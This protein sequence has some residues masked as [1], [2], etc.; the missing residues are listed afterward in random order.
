MCPLFL[1]TFVSRT[2][3]EDELIFKSNVIKHGDSAFIF[4]TKSNVLH[5]NV[6]LTLTPIMHPPVHCD[7]LFTSCG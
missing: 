4:I 2:S 1:D 7:L 6:A 3:S 5:K